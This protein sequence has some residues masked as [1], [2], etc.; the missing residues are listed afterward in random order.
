MEHKQLAAALGISPSM[1]S[2]LAKRGMPVDSVERAG[3]WR[4][5]HLAHARMKGNRVDT[6]PHPGY[7]PADRQSDVQLKDDAVKRVGD[8]MELGA[9]ALRAGMFGPLE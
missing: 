1:V 4:R 9:L 2:G 3:R 5:R 7:V 8:L 6:T